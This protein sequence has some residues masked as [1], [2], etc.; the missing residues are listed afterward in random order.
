MRALLRRAFP[1]LVP[2]SVGNCVLRPQSEQGLG[3]RLGFSESKHIGGC[4][5]GRRRGPGE[6]P[7]ASGM[8]W[9]LTGGLFCSTTD[10]LCDLGKL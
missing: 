9:G 1:L 5:V 10:R 3:T 8:P 4:L 6:G 2:H 7:A